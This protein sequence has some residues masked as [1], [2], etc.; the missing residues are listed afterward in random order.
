M[1][2]ACIQ[3]G[4]AATAAQGPADHKGEPRVLLPSALTVTCAQRRTRHEQCSWSL[5]MHAW[6][7]E[8]LTAI[9]AGAHNSLQGPCCHDALS[10]KLIEQAGAR[11]CFATAAPPD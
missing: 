4:Q 2:G 9:V 6:M 7:R 3:D 8:C 11:A 10:A 5:C 1:R